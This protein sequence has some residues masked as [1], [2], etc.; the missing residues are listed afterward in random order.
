MTTLKIWALS[1]SSKS[2]EKVRAMI[3]QGDPTWVAPAEDD[4]LMA[5]RPSGYRGLELWEE[6][7]AAATPLPSDQGVLDEAHAICEKSDGVLSGPVLVWIQ[8]YAVINRDEESLVTA[9][10]AERYLAIAVR[11]TAP[12]GRWERVYRQVR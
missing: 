10:I 11:V 7:L 1:S 8:R 12:T 9:T 6:E 3:S 2:S 4:F 5:H